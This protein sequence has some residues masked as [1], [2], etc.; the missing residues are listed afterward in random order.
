MSKYVHLTNNVVDFEMTAPPSNVFG[1]PY[2]DEFVFTENDNVTTGWRY[3]N[4]VFIEPPPVIIKTLSISMR[5]ARLE[6]LNRNLL[7]DVNTALSSLSQAAQI[8]W[9]YATEVRREHPLVAQL[10]A[11]LNMSES[12]MDSFF[13]AAKLL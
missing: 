6:L 2:C 12:D 5:Q 13:D 10:S 7:D 4:E 9:E 11:L 8:E 3:E 1:S